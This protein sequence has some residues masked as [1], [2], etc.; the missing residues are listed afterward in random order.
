M[1]RVIFT[2]ML[3]LS[4]GLGSARTYAYPNGPCAPTV[5][6]S[7]ETSL[8]GVQVFLLLLPILVPSIG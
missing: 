5:S 8:S 3:V 6:P 7:R 1:K 4:L 2:L